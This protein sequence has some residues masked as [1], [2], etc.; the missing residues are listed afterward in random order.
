MSRW[1]RLDDDVVHDRKVQDLAPP[2]FKGWINILCLASKN[3]GILPSLGDVAFALHMP[4]QKAIKLIDALIASC[5]LDRLPN[6]DLSPHHWNERQFKS[7]ISSDRVQKY[8]DKRK[9]SGLPNISDY[10]RFRAS[11]VNRDGLLCVYCESPDRLVV[12]H[13]FPITLGGSD[14]PDNLC[15]ACKSCNAG[16]AGRTPEMAGLKF[17]VKSARDAYLRYCKNREDVTVTPIL[18]PK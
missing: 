11:L 16:K 15:L 17:R 8:R 7:D 9:A 14:H 4:S 10:G 5:L 3:D 18:V 6:G 13:M 12:D 1:F 2:T